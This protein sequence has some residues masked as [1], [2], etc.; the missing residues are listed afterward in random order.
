MAVDRADSLGCADSFLG[1]PQSKVT[2]I[3]HGIGHELIEPPIIAQGKK[4][5][6]QPGMTIALEPKMVV[7]NEFTAGVE[8]VFVVTESGTRLLSRVPVEIFIC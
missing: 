8:S 6:L 2:F 3:G 7:E 4:D 5:L 1:A